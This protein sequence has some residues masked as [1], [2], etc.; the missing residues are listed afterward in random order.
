[1]GDK[2][3]RKLDIFQDLVPD[4]DCDVFARNELS[5]PGCQPARNW[6]TGKG[7]YI[8]VLNRSKREIKHPNKNSRISIHIILLYFA[9]I[10]DAQDKKKKNHKIREK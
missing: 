3:I 10:F 2:M 5:Q 6:D 1:M 4:R 9:S 8:F 7:V